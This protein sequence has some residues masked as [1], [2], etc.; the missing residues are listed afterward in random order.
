MEA[1]DF[2][3]TARRALAMALA[4]VLGGCSLGGGGVTPI[5]T[6][7]NKGVYF[8]NKKDYEPAIHEYRLAVAQNT[9]DYRAR[10]NLAMAYEAQAAL[11]AKRDGPAGEIKA[12]RA[13]ARTQYE[14]ALRA[15]PDELRASVNLAVMDWEAGQRDVARERLRSLASAR[16]AEALPL[17]SLGALLLR[18]GLNEQATA[19]LRGAVSR[20]PADPDANAMLAEALRRQHKLGEARAALLRAAKNAPNDTSVLVALG[21]LALEADQPEQAAGD[22]ARALY[23]DPDLL[24]AHLLRAEALSR[25]GDWVAAAEHLARAD[26]LSEGRPAAEHQAIE[27]RLR[28]LL[29]KHLRA[30]PSGNTAH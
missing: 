6:H 10:V 4:V 23:I 27:Q 5:R 20:D 7:F 29:E 26:Q 3:L 30:D 9:S 25:E 24:E 18:E 1:R 14:E 15:Q 12:M 16:P 22:L 21:R 28:T 17:V 13:L 19:T 8:Q 2:P 11:V